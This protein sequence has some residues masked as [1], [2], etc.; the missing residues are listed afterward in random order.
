MHT[1]THIYTHRDKTNIGRYTHISTHVLVYRQMH[2]DTHTH[3][4]Q[5]QNRDRHTQIHINTD[6]T[7]SPRHRHCGQQCG[8]EYA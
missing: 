4:L 3:I 2:T 5:P 8:G 6:T 7:H 1:K